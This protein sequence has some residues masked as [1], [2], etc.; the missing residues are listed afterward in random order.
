MGLP[1]RLLKRYK[2]VCAGFIDRSDFADRRACH[3]AT[4]GT[5]GLLG[6]AWLL[7]YVVIWIARW[8]R[9]GFKPS[10]SQPQ[11]PRADAIGLP[12][13]RRR[14]RINLDDRWHPAAKADEAGD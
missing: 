8:V 13:R 5:F 14:Q 10:G 9:T 4:V 11:R 3:A 12:A 7:I 6:L 1:T 2:K